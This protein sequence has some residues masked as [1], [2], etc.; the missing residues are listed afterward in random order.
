M[1][2]TIKAVKNNSVNIV[3][4]LLTTESKPAHEITETLGARTKG[5]F[6]STQRTFS[7]NLTTYQKQ[8]G[9][10]LPLL[11][12][13]WERRASE[14]QREKTISTLYTS[15][16]SSLQ[17]F[18]ALGSKLCHPKGTVER[19]IWWKEESNKTL[20]LPGKGRKPS[21]DQ[22]NWNIQPWCRCRVN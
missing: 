20:L 15:P 13:N 19:S 10:N 9:E 16:T 18:N 17:S 1:P 21:L 22:I 4:M 12:W 5:K 7:T 14:T 2:G 3:N 6:T 11:V 8:E